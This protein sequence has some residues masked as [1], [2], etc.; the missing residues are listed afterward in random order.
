MTVQAVST[1]WCANCGLR[2]PLQLLVKYRTTPASR[3]QLLCVKCLALEFADED[4]PQ[5]AA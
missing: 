5:D 4:L 3:Q 2:L 1:S